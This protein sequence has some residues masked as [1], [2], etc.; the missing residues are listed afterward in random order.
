MMQARN[1]LP[2]NDRFNPAE[3]IDLGQ[4]QTQPNYI[5]LAPEEPF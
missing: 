5:P 4:I 1:L 2:K 3:A